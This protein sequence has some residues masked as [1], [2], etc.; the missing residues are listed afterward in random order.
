MPLSRY[1]K[2]YPCTEKPGSSIIYSTKKGSVIR[3]T[4]D[5]LA[6]AANDNLS[7]ADRATLARLEIITDDPV[8]E[9]KTMGDIISRANRRQKKFR[10]IVVLNLDCNLA[11]AY[12][13]EDQFRGK[14]YM[15]SAT[16]DLL[17]EFILQ[18]HISQGHEV[19][20]DFYGA[21][22]RCSPSP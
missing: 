16:A 6:A 19:E 7:E 8:V 15:S 11:C 3:V 12:C 13:Y 17:L 22:N 1:L 5:L 18:N 9:R 4:A 2:I 21:A 10:G 20:V 14:H